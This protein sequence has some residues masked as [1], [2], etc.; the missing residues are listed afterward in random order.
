MNFSK[1]KLYWI[2]GLIFIILLS[3][4][5]L[6]TTSAP[7]L[8]TT[9]ELITISETDFKL[10]FLTGG[11]VERIDLIQNKEIVRVYIKADSLDKDYYV[12]IFKK[13]IDKAKVKGVPLFVFSVTDWNSFN[14]RLQK[15]YEQKG[16]K[17]VPQNTISETNKETEN[18]TP[19]LKN[20]FILIFCLILFNFVYSFL[21]SQKGNPYE[22]DYKN[23][24]N[25]NDKMRAL[26]LG[27]L[28]YKWNRKDRVL[29]VYDETAIANDLSIM[30]D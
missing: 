2:Y 18:E 4:R 12:Q 22:V 24:L 19:F 21:K 7:E 17:E 26:E 5:F 1:N 9:T 13:K 20:F 11:D 14:E 25:G 29:T 30:K 10:V 27:R 28:Y 8:S 16:I 3:I 6:N 23:A 15:F